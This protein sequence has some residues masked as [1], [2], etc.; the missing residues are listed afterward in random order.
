MEKYYQKLKQNLKKRADDFVEKIKQEHRKIVLWGTGGYG[1]NVFL[2]LKEAGLENL[3]CLWGDNDSTKWNK[4]INNIEIHGMEYYKKNP[5]HYYIIIC[6]FWEEQIIK[7]CIEE[8]IEWTN[9]AWSLRMI[10]EID[11]MFEEYTPDMKT[12][13]EC[14]NLF[15]FHKKA[16]ELY[17]NPEIIEKINIV[18]TLLVDE[19][20]KR[21]FDERIRFVMEGDLSIYDELIVLSELYFKKENYNCVS[22]DETF[23]DCGAYIG[24]SIQDFL[25]AVDY[26]YSQVIGYEPGKDN[27]RHLYKFFAENNIKGQIYPYAVGKS[28]TNV[29]FVQSGIGG[30]IQE[31]NDEKI[32]MISMDEHLSIPV[33]WIKMDIEGFELEALKGAKKTIQKNRP[34]LAI[35]L[36]HCAKDIYEIALWLHD[37]V[38][39]YRFKVGQHCRSRFDFCLYAD[40]Y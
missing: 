13:P 23:V 11:K 17:S 30:R 34:K 5:S 31:N 40:I 15:L 36:Y 26:S 21:I 9:E 24:D 1:R 39:E 12:F 8:G 35:C 10:C 4:K 25:K 18:R 6:S 16:E 38:P 28:N 19:K 29:S 27:Y 22:G 7:Q 14:N 20:S 3:I 32:C 33:T 2:Y 37:V